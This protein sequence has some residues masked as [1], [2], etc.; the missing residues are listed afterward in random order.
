M[1]SIVINNIIIVFFFFMNVQANYLFSQQLSENSFERKLIYDEKKIYL[2]IVLSHSVL[3]EGS[4]LKSVFSK[5]NLDQK[6][7]FLGFGTKYPW[8]EDYLNLTADIN[9]PLTSSF[10]LG[11]KSGLNSW[12]RV[13][14]YGNGDF[15]VL[16]YMNFVLGSFIE[17][18]GKAGECYKLGTTLNYHR[19]IN[20]HDDVK[21]KKINTIKPGI[22]FG[23]VFPLRNSTRFGWNLTFDYY[24]GG[25]VPIG[26]YES[27]TQGTIMAP[28]TKIAAHN[29]AIG[30]LFRWRLSR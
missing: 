7:S 23:F 6:Y 9:Y 12:G 26:P 13:A 10:S 28:R 11:I 19:I 18:N 22:Y 4:P 27:S 24:Y 30:N 8:Y 3:S 29:I 14:G 17:L 25:N 5:Y 21:N 16:R 2:S 1:N 20:T 15:I